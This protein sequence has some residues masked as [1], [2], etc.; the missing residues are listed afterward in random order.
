M[1]NKIYNTLFVGINKG[2]DTE[3]H[4]FPFSSEEKANEAFDSWIAKAKEV[5]GERLSGFYDDC[6][7]RDADLVIDGGKIRIEVSVEELEWSIDS[8]LDQEVSILP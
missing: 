3:W 1:K 5:L 4:R 2:K 8:P 7:Y 6:D